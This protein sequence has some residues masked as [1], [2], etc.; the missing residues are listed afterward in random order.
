M[1]RHILTT[2]VCLLVMMVF[3]TGTLIAALTPEQRK[4]LKEIGSDLSKIAGLVSKKKYDDAATAIQAAEDR[5]TK[6]VSDAG[7]KATDPILKSANIQLEKAKALL[8]KANNK[9]AAKQGVNFAKSIAPILVSKC[10]GCHSD[11]PK[12]GLNLGTFATMKKGGR[13]GDLWIPGNPDESL[14]MN[15]VFNENDE[16]RMPKGKEPLPEKEI[17][18][19]ATWIAEGAKFTG[20]EDTSLA[21]LAK[22]ASVT[23]PA[24][25]PRKIVIEK[26]TGTETVHFTKDLMPELVDTCGRCHNDTQKRS[27]FSVMSFE[28]LMKGGDSGVVVVGGSLEDSRLWRLVNGPD[29]G[30]P[31][32]PAGNQTGITRPWYNNLKK[33]IEEGARYD[34]D[35]PRKNFPSLAEREAAAMARFTPE[36]WVELRKKASDAQWKKTFPSIEPRIRES[37]EFLIYGDVGEERLEHIEKL[38]MEQVASLRHTFKVKDEPLWKGKL[39]VFL[40]KERFGYEEFNNSV[41]KREVPPEVIG[42]AEVS[43]TMEEAF[44]ALQDVGDSPS[45]SSPGMQVNLIEQVTAA[46]LKRG[47]GALPDWLIRGTGLALAHRKAAGNPYLQAMPRIASGILHESNL[48]EPEKIFANGTFSPGE[49]GPIGFTLVE[50]LLKTRDVGQFNQFV[51]KLKSGSSAE[52]AIKSTY[53]MEAKAVA[54]AYANSLPIGAKKGKGKP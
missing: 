20:D 5:L 42:H 32:M 12:G 36:Q 6:F 43:A 49:V 21:D 1:R 29:N 2:A 25:A 31:V 11:D 17:R 50:F 27:G 38:A 24:A 15:R 39:A 44:I 35:D 16:L 45:D 8:E 33:W 9:G 22:A 51:Q 46:F 37:A 4:E 23:K 13:S 47:S 40:F 18:L 19:I 30:T 53:Q 14:I 48:T 52:D 26:E 54:M 28:K 3:A 10:V 34:G 41:Q 7:V